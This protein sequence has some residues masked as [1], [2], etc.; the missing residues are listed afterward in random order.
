MATLLS[1]PP[2]R[3]ATALPR[4][5]PACL[6]DRAA[7]R[8]SARPAPR[9]RRSARPSSRGYVFFSEQVES[10]ALQQVGRDAGPGAQSVR[11]R[12]V[13]GLARAARRAA[14]LQHRRACSDQTGDGHR[15]LSAANE[16][17]GHVEAVP[18]THDHPPIRPITRRR[19]P[20]DLRGR[21]RRGQSAEWLGT[22]GNHGE[23]GTELQ[24]CVVTVVPAI[25]PAAEAEETRAHQQTRSVRVGPGRDHPS[26]LTRRRREGARENRSHLRSSTR[27]HRLKDVL[28][29]D[30]LA[31]ETQKLRRQPLSGLPYTRTGLVIHEIILQKL[32]DLVEVEERFVELE[33]DLLQ[34]IDDTFH[35]FP[36]PQ[37]WAVGPE[38]GLTCN[39]P[40]T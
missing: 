5:I 26:R 13:V 19:V 10:R 14:R 31:A 12:A 7:S 8:H 23:L 15:R 18:R 9:R 20:L 3:R 39:T 37:W 6:L 21:P 32:L 17:I 29:L 25:E 1:R 28:K 34:V 16:L 38:L 40:P 36:S 30:D 35:R 4:A 33:L 2:E 11:E 22:D 24:H 27:A